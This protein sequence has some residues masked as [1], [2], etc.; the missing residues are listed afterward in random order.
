MMH[1][2]KMKD[3]QKELLR[4]R[5]IC[6]EE[7]ENEV[8]VYWFTEWAEDLLKLLEKMESRIW[9]LERKLDPKMS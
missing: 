3:L 1:R 6:S 7:Q 2:M 8:N 9:E 5:K 4:N